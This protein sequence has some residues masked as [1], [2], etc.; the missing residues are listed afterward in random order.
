MDHAGV[1]P[2]PW[3]CLRDHPVI[4]FSPENKSSCDT[5][6]NYRESQSMLVARLM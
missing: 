2:A 6:I 1:T 3:G 4:A 5:Y